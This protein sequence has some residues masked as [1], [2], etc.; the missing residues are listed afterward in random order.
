MCLIPGQSPFPR[1]W[2]RRQSLLYLVTLP[3]SP[4]LVISSFSSCLEGSE[5]HTALWWKKVAFRRA[6]RSP[7]R[8]NNCARTSINILMEASLTICP[9]A[10]PCLQKSLGDVPHLSPSS[11]WVHSFSR[12]W[13]TEKKTKR[14]NFWRSLRRRHIFPSFLYTRFFTKDASH[15][16]APRF[17]VPGDPSLIEEMKWSFVISEKLLLLRHACLQSLLLQSGNIYV[18][19]HH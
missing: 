16:L 12:T 3:D 2:E 4:E 7:Y 19:V 11:F 15:F 6:R 8:G 1:S 5:V 9:S 14:L 18:Y 13:A 17:Q 10:V